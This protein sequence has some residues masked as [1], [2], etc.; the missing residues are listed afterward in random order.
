MSVF[1][2]RGG[3]TK[4]KVASTTYSSDVHMDIKFYVFLVQGDKE[5]ILFDAI[6]KGYIREQIGYDSIT[7]PKTNRTME[8]PQ[9]EVLDHSSDTYLKIFTSIGGFG[10]QN[11]Y[12]SRY[13]KLDNNAISTVSIFNLINNVK[14]I[15]VMGFSTRGTLLNDSQTQTLLHNNKQ[16]LQFYNRQASLP[17][18]MTN[19]MIVTGVTQELMKKQRIRRIRL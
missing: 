7:I 4:R 9:Y 13:V 6:R 1:N 8:L 15:P 3:R 16:G 11:R 2:Y 14:D 17:V 19:R 12:I 10:I 18:S 5:L